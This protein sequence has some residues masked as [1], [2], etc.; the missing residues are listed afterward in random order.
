[1]STPLQ[2]IKELALLSAFKAKLDALSLER[3]AELKTREYRGRFD[4]VDFQGVIVSRIRDVLASRESRLCLVESPSGSGK[5]VMEARLAADLPGKVLVVCS[6]R[7]ALGNRLSGGIV[8]K[9]KAFLE[10]V[11]SSKTVSEPNEPDFSGDVM[12]FTPIALDRLRR[13]HPA[14]FGHLVRCCE[15]FLIDE[16]HHFPHDSEG[17]LEVFDKVEEIAREEF[18]SRGK[19]VVGFTATCFRLDGKPVLGRNRPD[20]KLTLQDLI[21]LGRCPEIRGIQAFIDVELQDASLSGDFYRLVMSEDSRRKYWRAIVERMVEVYRRYPIPTC[22][23]VRTKAEAR[24]VATLFNR[25]SGLG[26]RKGLA[27]L[28]ADTPQDERQELLPRLRRGDLAGYVTCQVGEESIDVPAIGVVH[29]IRRTR[30]LGR[31]LQALGRGTRILRYDDPAL[32]LYARWGGKQFV[33]VVDYQL[34]S[35]SIIAGCSGLAEMEDYAGG[36]LRRCSGGLS[37]FGGRA[38]SQEAGFATRIDFSQERDWVLNC[39]KGAQ[40]GQY[41]LKRLTLLAMLRLGFPTPR[42]GDARDVQ[43][44]VDDQGVPLELLVDGTAFDLRGLGVAV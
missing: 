5:T 35:R 41:R 8:A 22:A 1:M 40:D 11:G 13:R 19:A 18:L 27:V 33:L 6:S 31:N 7:T 26:T 25:L 36:F 29:L 44:A 20:I 2:D 12:F 42:P 30:S 21:N 32:P 14:T 28:L 37:G 3:L 10:H 23:F 43:L 9:F 4:D 39:L 24:L 17:D 16:V 15:V 34:M 38:P